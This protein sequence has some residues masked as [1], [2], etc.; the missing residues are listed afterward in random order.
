M[1]AVLG[2][3]SKEGI[4]SR[5]VVGFKASNSIVLSIVD[6]VMSIRVMRYSRIWNFAL[7]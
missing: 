1:Y 3:A 5:A 6:A 7:M 4:P 2:G